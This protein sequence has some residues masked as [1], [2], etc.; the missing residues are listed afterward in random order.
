[1]ESLRDLGS[2]LYSPSH[3]DSRNMFTPHSAPRFE[4]PL[5]YVLLKCECTMSRFRPAG[6]EPQA[7]P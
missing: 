3:Q 7:F 2:A 4:V 6:V 5:G 1:M